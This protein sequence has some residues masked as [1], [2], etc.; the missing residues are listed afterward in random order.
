MP[1]GMTD[2]Q[3]LMVRRFDAS[4]PPIKRRLRRQQRW[5][6][7]VMEFFRLVG[8]DELGD[9]ASRVAHGIETQ[10]MFQ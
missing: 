1:Y 2:E 4:L 8:R 9:L 6:C 7:N 3:A 10:A 5:T